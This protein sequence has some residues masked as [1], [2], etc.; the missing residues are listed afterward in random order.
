MGTECIGSDHLVN[1]VFPAA[2]I[3][4]QMA[5]ALLHHVVKHIVGDLRMILRLRGHCLNGVALVIDFGEE[6]LLIVTCVCIINKAIRLTSVAVSA[7][8]RCRHDQLIKLL[9]FA[10]DGDKHFAVLPLNLRD[11]A[12]ELCSVLQFFVEAFPDVLRSVLPRPEVDVDKVHR[13]LEVKILQNIGGWNLVKIAVTKGCE[14]PDPDILH[15]L[16]AVLFTEGLEREGQIF[17]IGVAELNSLAAGSNRI[18]VTSALGNTAVAVHIIASVLGFQNLAELLHLAL[19]LEEAGNLQDIFFGFERLNHF[20]G[21]VFVVSVQFRAVMCDAAEFF[22][23]MHGIVRGH[24]HNSTHLVSLSLVGGRPA[25]AAY[26]IGLLVDHIVFIALFLEIHA[27]GKA[28]RASADNCH[29]YIFVHFHHSSGF[30]FF[31][32]IFYMA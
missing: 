32:L 6:G 13:R 2:V 4:H 15:E 27:R 21:T 16:T 9:D 3:N 14:G 31:I 18:A 23:V 17:Q 26:A 12:V 10:V 1:I 30:S 5:E 22:H 28:C 25:L 11:A 8:K 20:T 7:V 24:T 19:H 29:A